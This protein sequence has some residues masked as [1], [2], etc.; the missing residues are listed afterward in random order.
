MEKADLVTLASES[1]HLPLL[2][3]PE[4]EADAA[5]AATE[6]ARDRMD[7]SELDEMLRKLQRET[8]QGFRVFRPGDDIDDFLASEGIKT[9]KKSAKT[10][11]ARGGDEL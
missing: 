7:D 10:K 9:S 5:E 6:N 1:F 2:Q 8:G 4:E 3:V 11:N